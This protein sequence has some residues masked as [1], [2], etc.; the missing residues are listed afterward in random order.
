MPVSIQALRDGFAGLVMGIDCAQPLSSAE[1]AAVEAGMDRYGV[2][3]FRDQQLT[4]AGQLRF[5]LHFGVIEKGNLG[6]GRIHFR[7]EQEARAL[8]S[9]IGDFSNMDGAGQPLLP[10]SRAYMFKLADRM[11]HSDSS[12]KA[13][14]AKYS[15]LSGR[16]VPS[17]GG[18]TEFA[19]M[20]AAYDALDARTRREI[21]D[22]VCR[23]SNMYSREKSG[24]TELSEEERIA[25]EP[26]RQRLVR[27]HPV[28]GRT[29]LFLSSH[30]GMVEGMSIPE[31]RVLLHDLM[32]FATRERFVYAHDW[33]L[34]DL[35]MWDNRTTMHRG[36]RFDP[37]E[38][39]DMRQTRLAGDEVTIAQDA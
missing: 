23:H 18:A 1:V 38:A 14:P 19:D 11:W 32:D 12:F 8:G 20:R 9:G 17:W 25:F 36:R 24:F 13:I 29:S 6:V 31:G 16:A 4:D 26:V 15:L 28:T 27:R 10:T 3:V 2:L 35:V 21:E 33:Q 39:R 30:A 22:L 37:K 5:T 7:T 34:H